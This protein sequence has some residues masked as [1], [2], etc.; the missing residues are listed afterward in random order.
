MYEAAR[1]QWIAEA[2]LGTASMRPRGLDAAISAFVTAVR[3]WLAP[4]GRIHRGIRVH[5]TNSPGTG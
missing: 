3:E 1:A 2:E 5:L 4:T